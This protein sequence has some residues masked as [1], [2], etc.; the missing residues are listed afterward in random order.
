MTGVAFIVYVQSPELYLFLYVA[1]ASAGHDSHVT[2]GFL[3]LHLSKA[4]F[5]QLEAGMAAWF[6]SIFF[7]SKRLSLYS[8]FHSAMCAQADTPLTVAVE[9]GNL[10]MV[11]LLC[12]YKQHTKHVSL[13]RLALPCRADCMSTAGLLS[14]PSPEQQHRC[15]AG[16]LLTAN[17]VASAMVVAADA[18]LQ[19]L[20][21]PA[22]HLT[23]VTSGLVLQEFHDMFRAVACNE[24]DIVEH[25]LN[26]GLDATETLQVS[27]ASTVA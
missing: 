4:I 9:S 26:I 3:F 2:C 13:L 17:F 18:C 16:R 12:S 20:S 8:N 27:C 19:D 25:F 21:V 15:G 1:E 23:D 14:T 24:I 7:R 11:K 6:L 22:S 10:D 5:V